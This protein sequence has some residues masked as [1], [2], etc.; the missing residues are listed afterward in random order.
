[1]AAP[2]IAVVDKSATYQITG[3]YT[4]LTITRSSGGF[5]IQLDLTG[6]PAQ[7][8]IAVFSVPNVAV[9][10]ELVSFWSALRGY[11]TGPL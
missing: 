9:L 10:D 1:M 5:T 4:V 8:K 2:S 3:T 11:L 6:P 7:S